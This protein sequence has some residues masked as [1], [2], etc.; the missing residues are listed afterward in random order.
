L[1]QL[2]CHAVA[3]IQSFDPETLTVEAKINYPM[4]FY[5][6]DPVTGVIGPV[7]IDYPTLVSC[8]VI[9][10]QG[11]G[12]IMT[13]PIAEGDSCV[14]LFNDRALDAW[15]HSGQSL[16]LNSNRLHAFEDAMALPGLRPQTNIPDVYDDSHMLLQS[17]DGT[18]QLG[19]SETQVLISNE[20]GTL[21]T[22][23]GNLMTQVN[24]ML[25][26]I[27]AINSAVGTILGGPTNDPVPAPTL[28]AIGVQLTEINTQLGELLE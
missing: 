20:D 18:V 27:Q 28:V 5:R 12:F 10:P 21:G 23:L 7:S 15:I 4:T 26:A 22:I 9:L 3:T 1:L 13:A 19:V 6:P 16:P 2:N 8:P 24:A 17:P 14:I 11:G 25:S